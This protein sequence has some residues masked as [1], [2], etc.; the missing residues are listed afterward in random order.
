MHERALHHE[1]GLDLL[2]ATEAAAI[3][4]AQTMGQ[5]DRHLSDRAAVEAMREVLD[6]IFMKG[7]IV[8]GEGERDKAPMLYIG[9]H[10]GLGWRLNTADLNG[11]IFPGVHIAVDPL[12]GTNLCAL[13][14]P[15]AITTIAAAEPGGL[16]GAPDIYMEKLIVG[17]AARGKVELEAPVKHNLGIIAS[18]LDRRIEDLVVV[19]LDRPRHTDLVKE[20]RETGARIQFIS[21]GDLSAGI[22][23]AMGESGVHAVLGIGGAPE[24]VLTAAA[25]KCLN[26]EVLT[27]FLVKEQLVDRDDRN[28]VPADAAARLRDMGI[29]DPA[30]VYTTQ[31]LA[32]GQKITFAATGVTASTNPRLN[33]VRFFSGGV[34]TWSLVMNTEFKQVTYVD[35]VHMDKDNPNVVVRL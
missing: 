10:L 3:A 18:S 15:G 33:G 32:P 31:D 34:R 19:V 26:G 35:R 30:Q 29:K 6:T 20:I 14:Q 2:R 16:L 9:E 12:E 7:E 23:A 17:P 11:L 28:K 24:G 1:L 21:D 4:S 27:R 8:I 5:G 13:G 22:N 25:M